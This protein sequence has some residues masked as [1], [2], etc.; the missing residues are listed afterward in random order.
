MFDKY[1]SDEHIKTELVTSIGD[2]VYDWSQD[3]SA[4]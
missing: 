4:Q 1:A 2:L 3:K